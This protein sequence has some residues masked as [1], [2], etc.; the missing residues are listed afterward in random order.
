MFFVNLNNPWLRIPKKPLPKR[1]WLWQQY[2]KKVCNGE[3]KPRHT[4]GAPLLYAPAVR[5]WKSFMGVEIS[6]GI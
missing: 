3:S 2:L 1:G 5:A 4:T 6:P